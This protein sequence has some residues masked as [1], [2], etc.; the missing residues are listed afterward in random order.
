MQQYIKRIRYFG[1]FTCMYKCAILSTW[2]SNLVCEAKRYFSALILWCRLS[3]IGLEQFDTATVFVKLS[4]LSVLWFVC[5]YYKICLTLVW[6]SLIQPLCE[7]F[8]TFS[9]LIFCVRIADCQ[10]LVWSSL[11][12]PLCLWSCWLRPASW[13]W[14]FYRSTTFTPPSSGSATLNKS[15]KEANRSR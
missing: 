2:H 13:S 12:R 1:I 3:D 9:T 4:E 5:S 15:S 6:G 7:T 10:I 14:S 11:T 8:R